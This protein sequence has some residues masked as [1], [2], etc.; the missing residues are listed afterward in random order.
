[1]K[2]VFSGIVWIGIYL[3]L[4]LAPL[5]VLLVGPVPPGAGFWWDLS[6]AIGFAGIAMLGVQF[7]L[8]AR[9]Q[10]ASA[11]FGLDIVY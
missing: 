1:M 7:V 5:L 2:H 4:V 8:T 9:F 11:P 6:M 3:V 10:R